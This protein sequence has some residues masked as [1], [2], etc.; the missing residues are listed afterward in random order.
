[1]NYR[2]LIGCIWKNLNNSF[3]WDQPGNCSFFLKS[4][5]LSK[6][7]LFSRYWYIYELDSTYVIDICVAYQRRMYEW[8]YEWM[9]KWMKEQ[10]NISFDIV[11]AKCH[12]RHTISVSFQQYAADCKTCSLKFG[13]LSVS[14]YHLAHK[15]INIWE[16]ASTLE[17]Y[18]S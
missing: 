2:P 14:V 11:T 4:S 8:M 3:K 7:M 18:Y 1:M 12:C 5:V 15:Y 9:N 16:K 17:E 6:L 10:M 13:S